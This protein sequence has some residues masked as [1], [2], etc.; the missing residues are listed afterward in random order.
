LLDQRRLSDLDAGLALVAIP[1][2]APLAT[3]TIGKGSM[4][5]DGP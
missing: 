2:S 3:T 4:R 1:A 5:T